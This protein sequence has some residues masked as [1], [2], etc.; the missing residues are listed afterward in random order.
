[1]K[2]ADERITKYGLALL[3]IVLIG[4]FLRVYQLGTQS[5]WYD[6]SYSIWL[7]KLAVPQ[8]VQTI[9]GAAQPPLYYLLLHYWMMV[10]GTSESA[11]R[12]LSA[13]FGVL[14][15]PM[16]YVVG[17]QLFNKEVGLVGALIL[18]LSSFNIWYSQETRMYSLM[19][20]LALLSM[21]FFLC[22]LQRGTLALS[23]G[24]VLST[25][26]LLYTHYY[27]VFVVIA[28]NIYIVT[29]LVLSKQRTYKL[30]HWIGLQA[31]V[32]ALFAPWMM[33]VLISQSVAGPS[34]QSVAGPSSQSVAGAL[35]LIS[36]WI[37]Q[38][39]AATLIVTYQLYC[40]TVV[41]VA[42]SGTVWLLTA[43]LS[44]LFLGLS[45]FSLFAYQKVR[46]AMDRKAPLKSLES[47]SW[48]VR[49]QD[50]TP[51]YFLA[52]WLL[53]IN[54]IPFVISLVSTPI[55]YVRYTIAASV[56]LY[57]LVGKGITNIN[58]KPTK[59]AVIG[60]VAA[61]SV[62][63]LPSYYF[64]VTR[65][66]AREATSL[67]DANAKSGDVILIYPDFENLTFNYYNNRTDVAVKQIAYG[68]GSVNNPEATTEALQSDVNGHDRVWFYDATGIGTPIENFT[69]NFLNESYAKIYVK[70]YV[71]YD[72]YLYEK[73]A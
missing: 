68:N 39:T 57:L 8:M 66:Q 1:M 48:E 62:A 72:V 30:R 64:G 13:L 19:V 17:R 46:G 37:P 28:Q 61:L 32:L 26:L 45:V 56:A 5:I 12:L 27:G 3:A 21:Y 42:E 20:L 29:L 40:G 51:V 35:H 22:F 44:A 59:L 65:D 9:A 15:I 18:A 67:I 58:Y 11:V 73:R 54:L 14:A 43:V 53:A 4:L 60:V 38:P 31:I 25:M 16:I 34:S 70:S 6:E 49:I 52:V 24:Y 47:Y 2:I 69:L 7:S 50:L 23:A 10:F 71:G 41:L 55:Y 63:S 33:V 36:W